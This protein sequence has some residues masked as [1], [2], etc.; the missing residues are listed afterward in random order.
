MR[1]RSDDQL[2]AMFRG[3]SEEAFGVIHDRYRQRLFAYTRQ[4]L[5]GSSQDAEDALQDV[6]VKAYSGLRANDRKLALRAWLYRVAHNR[7]I[8][9]LRRPSPVV[10]LV[11]PPS[12]P[13]VDPAL[14]AEQRE[15]LKALIVDVQRLPEQQRS[16]LLMRE[17]SGMSYCDLAEA[18]GVSVPAVK[19]LLVR[20]RMGLTQASAA[21]DAACDDIR[22][23]LVDSHDRGVRATGAARRHLR[24]CES[25]R[26][27]RRDVRSLSRRFSVVVPAFGP[28][29]VIMKLLGVGGGAGGGSAAAGTA[30]GS[31]S[32]GTGAAAGGTAVGGAVAGGAAAGGGAALGGGAVIAGG[33][34][35]SAGHVAAL[36]AAALVTAGGA[37]A[38]HN[39]PAAHKNPPAVHARA[40]APRA[41]TRRETADKVTRVSVHAARTR[42][43]HRLRHH[44]AQPADRP[45]T[46]GATAAAGTTMQGYAGPGASLPLHGSTGVSATTTLGSAAISGYRR[47]SAL[48]TPSGPPAATCQTAAPAGASTSGS[49]PANAAPASDS[50]SAGPSPA[51]TAG[52]GAG[53]AGS[54]VTPSGGASLAGGASV[55]PPAPSGTTCAAQP[56]S[57]AA[58]SATGA[59]GGTTSAAAGAAGTPSPINPPTRA[60]GGSTS[61]GVGSSGSSSAT[62]PA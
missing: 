53:S 38:I 22:R 56:G 42:G 28:A 39:A 18:I 32:L 26:E 48:S 61:V 62:G 13:S 27:F 57:A 23:Q 41:T 14:I 20:A 47:T 9:Q 43:V 36:I 12:P 55:A 11:E 25:C 30:A 60:N 51:A 7:C 16:A 19:S 21:R 59:A 10:A 3:G 54:S 46:R 58:A 4:M 31:G 1:L 33:G 34:S 29:A 45:S 17:L 6:F 8:D 52:T 37:V 50:A 5:P 15:T 40:V 49:T 44:G 2:V 24:D 35:L